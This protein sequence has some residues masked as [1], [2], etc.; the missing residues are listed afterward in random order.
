ML[1]F[2][3]LL[4]NISLIISSGF[5]FHFQ[6]NMSEMWTDIWEL[7]HA[8]LSY[9]IMLSETESLPKKWLNASGDGG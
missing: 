5:H 8:F 3:H 1:A 9:F 7:N 2:D 4:A 6:I